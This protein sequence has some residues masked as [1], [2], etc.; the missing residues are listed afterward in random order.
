MNLQRL[1]D[2]EAALL[3]DGREI[4]RIS[5]RAVDGP[6]YEAVLDGIEAV[7]CRDTPPRLAVTYK[8]GLFAAAC[9]ET[10]IDLVLIE[11]DPHDDPPRQVRRQRTTAEPAAVAALLARLNEAPAMGA[12]R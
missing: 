8:E 2:G 5:A 10:T 3:L 9:S 7:L 12:R 1:G 6:F 4:I 11:E